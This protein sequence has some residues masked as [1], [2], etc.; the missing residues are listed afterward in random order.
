[1]GIDEIILAVNYMADKLRGYLGESFEGVKIRYSLESIP[2]GTGGPIKLAMRYLSKENPFLVVN[3][4]ILAEFDLKAMQK[5]HEKQK[6]MVTIGLHEVKDVSRF[7]VAKLRRNNQI[8]QFIEKPSNRQAPSHLVNA[9]IYMMTP[10]I[11][12]YIPSGKKVIIEREIF[13]ELAR[14]GR[15]YGFLHKG[16]WF[17]IGDI[18]DYK[19]ANFI[20]LRKISQRRPC[21]DPD[22]QVSASTRL[23]APVYIGNDS[24]IGSKAKLGPNTI[25]GGKCQIDEG[26]IIEGS[27]LFDRVSIGRGTKVSN[28]IIANDVIVGDNVRITKGTIIAGHTVI[29]D[30]VRLTRNVIVHPYKEVRESVLKPGHV[31]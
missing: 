6:A 22:A 18:S 31:M 14:K 24:K 15:L 3:G 23:E 17:D 10:E 28:S 27:I 2:L 5:L 29:F 16:L 20:L 9:G 13:P 8:V 19:S 21:V 7:G 26:A 4:D 1:M 11:F 12:H 25:V 30:S